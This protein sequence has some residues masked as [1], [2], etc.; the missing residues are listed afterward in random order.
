MMGAAYQAAIVTSSIP[1]I[2]MNPGAGLEYGPV[3][4]V[5]S[6]VMPA[7]P[8][9]SVHVIA[10]PPAKSTKSSLH[11]ELYSFYSDL[12]SLESVNNTPATQETPEHT[13]ANDVAPVG[14]VPLIPSQ[15]QH[16]HHHHQPSTQQ[17]PDS[18]STLSGAQ[19]VQNNHSAGTSYDEM[20]NKGD[21]SSQENR[22]RK[23]PK[24]APGLALKK[25]GVSSLVAKWQQVQQEVRRDFKNL[26]EEESV[27]STHK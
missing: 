1:G 11:A 6:M 21:T 13:S 24:L 7:M 3:Q 23:K 17:N 12:A 15:Q 10:K 5:P 25:K 27:S 18:N 9:A 14:S 2:P 22:K 20:S 26:D 8:T 19:A 16:H 4:Y